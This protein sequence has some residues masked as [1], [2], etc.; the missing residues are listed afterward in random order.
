MNNMKLVIIGILVVLLLGALIMNS[1]NF[2]PANELNTFTKNYPYNEG[3]K[4]IKELDR[5]TE[6]STY[7]DN[8][9]LDSYSKWE[10]TPNNN[11][12]YKVM[13]INGLVCSPSVNDTNPKDIYSEAKGSLD[14]PSYGLSN[15]KG[16]LCLDNKQKLLYTTRGGNASG[17]GG[18]IGLYVK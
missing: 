11:S 17:G 6:Y 15:S 18:D 3:F 5:K 7:P 2:V 8:N 12:C 9:P 14:C 10:I 16:F 1:Q 13:G 4:S